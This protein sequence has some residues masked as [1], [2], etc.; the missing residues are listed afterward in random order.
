MPGSG[1]GARGACEFTPAECHLSTFIAL[2]GLYRDYGVGSSG[3][4]GNVGTIKFLVSQ[5]DGRTM[6][7]IV[8]SAQETRRGGAKST[9]DRIL[10]ERECI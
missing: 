9:F 7:A 10:S 1:R 6:E 3:G 4:W 2:Y 8:A 5:K